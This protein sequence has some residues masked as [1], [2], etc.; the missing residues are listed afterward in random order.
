[1][2]LGGGGGGY[3]PPPPP[4]IPPEPA[5]NTPAATEEVRQAREREQ[6]RLRAQR[7]IASTILTGPRG[8][9]GQTGNTARKTLLGN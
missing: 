2:C 8:L 4:Q 1:M 9:V 3:T 5:T 7:G 6:D